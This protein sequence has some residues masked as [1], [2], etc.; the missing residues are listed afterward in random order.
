MSTVSGYLTKLISLIQKKK[1]ACGWLVDIG[2]RRSR[3]SITT[4][5]NLSC[6][7]SSFS[8]LSIWP[9]NHSPIPHKNISIPNFATMQQY[10]IQIDGEAYK[11]IPYLHRAQCLCPVIKISVK[12]TPMITLS[13]APIKQVVVV[14]VSISIFPPT[15]A[16]HANYLHHKNWNLLKKNETWITQNTNTY[17][18][19]NTRT[20]N[21][22]RWECIGK[23]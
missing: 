15:G 6:S 1:L 17:H 14:G 21:L 7:F 4:S 9:G 13:L 8:A 22:G 3:T 5:I 11:Q 2:I 18:V 19:T 12:L 20:C 23:R 16:S 10:T